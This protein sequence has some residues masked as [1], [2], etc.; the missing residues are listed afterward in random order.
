MLLYFSVPVSIVI[1]WLSVAACNGTPMFPPAV[2]RDVS[3]DF[4][5]KAW[6]EGIYDIS[7]QAERLPG[8]VQLGGEIIGVEQESDETLIV[9]TMLPIVEHPK[10][11]PKKLNRTPDSTFA[12]RFQKIKDATW[13]QRGNFFVVIGHPD[14]V[15]SVLVDEIRRTERHLTAQ[16]IHIW[17]NQGRDIASFPFET[18][19]GY[20]PLEEKTFC[21]PSTSKP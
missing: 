7:P 20:Y 6:K 11:G 16:C 17:K 18:G 3:S 15:K 12:I 8:K 4:N 19:A 21:R 14:G 10:Y 2:A 1:L 9:G 13:L 5:F